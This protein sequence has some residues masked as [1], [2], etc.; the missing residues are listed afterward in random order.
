[1]KKILSLILTLIILTLNVSLVSAEDFNKKTIIIT[2]DELD[3]LKSQKIINK[4]LSMGLLNIKTMG[5]NNES[6]FMTIATGRKVKINESIFK[7]IKRKD[8]TLV[9]E[10]YEDIKK[11][12][13]KDYPNF[14][15]QIS[16]LGEEL[17]KENINTSY[18]GDKDKSEV[19]M[20]TDKLGKIDYLE[21]ITYDLNNL[22]SKIEK[23]FKKSDI[24]LISYDL[25]NDENRID[26]LS[27]L[28]SDL[29]DYNLIVFPKTVS[30]DV[31]LRLNDSLVPIFYG[32]DGHSGILT[33][34]STKR[35]SVITTLDLFPTIASN[36]GLDVKSNIGNEIKVLKDTDLIATNKNILTEF[37]N[38][39]L[40]KY[41]FHAS[42]VIISLYIALKQILKY[43]SFKKVKVLLS[44]VMVSIPTSIILGLFFIHRYIYIY[45]FLLMSLSFL[46]AQYLEGKNIRVVKTVSIV[47]NLMILIFVFLNPNPLYNSYIGY[48]S[49]VAG[50]RFYGFNNE[51]M[52]VFIT[53]SIILYYSL[54]NKFRSKKISNI[55]LISYFFI[56]IIALTGNYG[57]NF[58]GFLTTIVLFLILLYLSLFNKRLNKKT[59]LSLLSI[60]ILI[61]VFNLYLDMNNENGSHAGGL[62]ERI[63]ILGLYE[64]IDMIIK[65][66]RQLLYM[67]IVPPWSIGLLSQV[68][69]FIFKFKKNKTVLKAIP[70]EFLV[71][72]ITSIVVLLVNDTGVV[73]FVYMNIYLINNILEDEGVKNL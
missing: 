46:I 17:E 32:N 33:S 62:I 13:D 57:A 34:N 31:N 27:S 56:I 4:K 67:V 40:V 2:L 47:T 53:T 72:F 6:L 15:K 9:V 68:S 37:L 71:M 18:I 7:G 49:I 58:G 59:I 64:F 28:L 16:F 41:I 8:D 45:V 54:K 26:I 19:L 51:L 65:K 44:A 21:E 29:D 30:G 48:N 10:G 20:I 63:N 22:K 55:F 25:D 52:G 50:G 36:Y 73:A 61:L 60:G 5:K 66:V 24:L 35:D 3:F 69:F 11:S 1:M 12:L 39:N 70:I 43:D 38:L 42:V 23:M 14:S